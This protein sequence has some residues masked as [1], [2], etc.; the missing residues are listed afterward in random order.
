MED[1]GLKIDEEKSRKPCFGFSIFYASILVL[2]PAPAGFLYN[3]CLRGS[4]I[5]NFPIRKSMDLPKTFGE[6]KASHYQLIP[7]KD[8]MRKNL[9]RKMQNAEP[10]FPGIIG[11]DET[12]IP[13]IQNAV[14][15]K[16]DMLFLG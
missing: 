13:Q 7:V 8:E 6:L 14:L 15:S 16:H 12:V 4:T 5:F 2:H 1:R 11:Y 10:L 9:I 3:E